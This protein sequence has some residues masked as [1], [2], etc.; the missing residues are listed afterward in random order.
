MS[1]AE[2]PVQIQ[3]RLKS[4]HGASRTRAPQ[5]P[6]VADDPL[7]IRT[8]ITSVFNGPG[9]VNPAGINPDLLRDGGC[10]NAQTE[11]APLYDAK[12]MFARGTR[13]LE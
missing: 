2:N 8:D 12:Q 1:S 7:Q 10:R 5:R 9:S 13:P 3:E 11:R 6:D 4:A